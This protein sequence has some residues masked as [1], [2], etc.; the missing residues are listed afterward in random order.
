M[1]DTRLRMEIISGIKDVLLHGKQADKKQIMLIGL[2]RAS[3]AYGLIAGDWQERMLIR[4]RCRE[5]SGNDEFST[6]TD[7]IIRQVRLAIAAAVAASAA[8]HV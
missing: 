7:Q 4:K 3:R 8:A 2:V 1:R 5:I 6:E